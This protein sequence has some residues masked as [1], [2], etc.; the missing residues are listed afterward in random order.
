[1]QTQPTNRNTELTDATIRSRK[2]SSF[3][4]LAEARWERRKIRI[5]LPR[6]ESC[7]T[8]QKMLAALREA[9]FADWHASGGDFLNSMHQPIH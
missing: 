3:L 1:M 4:Q 7:R 5:S 9:E 6:R 2:L 8:K